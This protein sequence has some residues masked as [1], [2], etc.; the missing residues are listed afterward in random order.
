MVYKRLWR[1]TILL[2]S[3]GSQSLTWSNFFM[4][5]LKSFR[6]LPS[7]F[8]VF[9]VLSHFSQK[10]CLCF[11][12]NSLFFQ[13]KTQILLRQS[14]FIS[15]VFILI[16]NQ[17]LSTTNAKDISTDHYITK[18]TLASIYNESVAV[19]VGNEARNKIRGFEPGQGRMFLINFFVY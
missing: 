11:S 1:Q 5:K 18:R 14:V 10:Q 6:T 19:E 16:N 13:S 15:K 12:T 9:I 3:C 2:C 17:L 4:Q 8:F 7:L